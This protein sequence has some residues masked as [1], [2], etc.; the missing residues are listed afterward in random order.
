MR[1]KKVLS[2]MMGSLLLT[3]GVVTVT[4]NSTK[5][6][7]AA[8]NDVTVTFGTG[9][10]TINASSVDFTDTQNNTWN[11]TTEGT[12]SFIANR[13][14]YQVGSSKK[15]AKSITFTM[16]AAQTA[17][18][19]NFSMKFGG[20]TGTAGTI[21]LTKGTDDLATA[22]LSGT[23][24]VTLEYANSFSMNANDSIIISI[25][26]IAKGVKVY[27]L[28]YTSTINQT[29]TEDVKSITTTAQL[30]FSTEYTQ[31]IGHDGTATLVTDASTLSVGDTLIITDSDYTTSL[32]TTQNKNNRGTA[33]ISHNTADSSVTFTC[34]TQVLTLENGSTEGTYSLK[35]GDGYLYAAGGTTTNNYLRTK[36]E[37]DGSS[38]WA[39]TIAETGVA[40]LVAADGTIQRN[41]LK[42]NSGNTCFSCYATGQNDISIFKVTTEAKESKIS[43]ES[44]NNYS[45]RFGS[46]ITENDVSGVLKE[47]ETW[48]SLNYGVL[49]TPKAQLSS[50]ASFEAIYKDDSTLTVDDIA[51][52]VN[53]RNV[54]YAGAEVVAHGGDIGTIL[55]NV[56]YT[57]VEVS[58]VIYVVATDGK[59]Y[60]SNQVDISINALAAEYASRIESLGLDEVTA[61]AVNALNEQLNPAA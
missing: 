20:F 28:S 34:D 23:N 38:S 43:F 27:N 21:K 19:S 3:L 47:G 53:A 30:G 40:S 13:D 49:V 32:S 11:V 46:T 4:N 35:V 2:A 36:T 45:L 31:T 10:V 44:F 26:D 52:L 5:D 51:T 29:P 22:S 39:L 48:A 7:N 25:T 58:A 17:T 50:Y 59:I 57:D 12:T 42:Y 16:T 24:D 60:F 37:K 41:T 9:N 1:L 15:P 6:V 61:A 33:T 18:I 55:R 56:P 8:T 14:Y 54:T